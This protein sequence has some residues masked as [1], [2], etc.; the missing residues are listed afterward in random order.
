MTT[1]IKHISIGVLTLAILFIAMQ[2]NTVK[3]HAEQSI[4]Q[5]SCMIK[6]LLLDQATNNFQQILEYGN[7][8]D[9]KSSE[10]MTG[11]CQT[12]SSFV[13]TTNDYVLTAPAISG[14]TYDSSRS[15]Y[16]FLIDDRTSDPPKII[17]DHLITIS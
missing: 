11:N 3:Q 8:P 2:P 9:Q 10:A 13:V 6:A 15:Q 7:S 16:A 4:S 1:T 14:R 5:S 12:M 17:V